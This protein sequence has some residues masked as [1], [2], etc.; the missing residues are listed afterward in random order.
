MVPSR[1]L[2]GHEADPAGHGAVSCN[3]NIGRLTFVLDAS[4]SS[5]LFNL[6]P[7]LSAFSPLLGAS[8]FG[9]VLAPFDPSSS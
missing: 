3:R 5:V 4:G 1:D 8:L 9:Q 7:R 6:D 2:L